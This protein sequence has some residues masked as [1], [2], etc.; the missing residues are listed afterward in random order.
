[1]TSEAVLL[2]RKKLLDAQ[3]SRRPQRRPATEPADV[4]DVRSAPPSA[5]SVSKEEMEMARGYTGR[6]AENEK[7]RQGEP[8]GRQAVPYPVPESW[9]PEYRTEYAPGEDP[10]RDVD[11]PALK[12]GRKPFKN[13]AKARNARISISLS[14]QE[15]D[16]IMSYVDE[17][18]IT[19]SAWFRKLA[20]RAM[21]R[22]IPKRPKNA[23]D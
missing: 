19:V 2:L 3:R 18:N 11:G 6:T 10:G 16:A 17:R 14:E 7:A 4:R 12:A 22:D 5:Q 8:T 23:E 20:F 1:M 9:E 15:R 13:R 21:G